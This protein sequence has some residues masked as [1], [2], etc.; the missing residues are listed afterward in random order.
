MKLLDRVGHEDE[1]VL[2]QQ[3]DPKR[4]AVRVSRKAVDERQACRFAQILIN[5]ASQDGLT[6]QGAV[7]TSDRHVL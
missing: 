3:F 7:S 6:N 2:L 4:E 5:E 1:I